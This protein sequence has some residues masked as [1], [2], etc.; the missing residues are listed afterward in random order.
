MNKYL[1]LICIMCAA[2]FASSCKRNVLKGE[3]DKT[4]TSLPVSSSF[5]AL[6]IALPLKSVINIAPGSQPSV[7]LSGYENVIRHIHAKMDKNTLRLETDLDEMW[8]LDSK[9]IS[10]IITV[11]SLVS[12]E[13]D[14]TSDA[15]IHGA[16]IAN[17]FHLSVSG[18][19]K[20]VIDNLTAPV[21]SADISGA[22]TLAINGGAARKS[23]YD[24][25]G[26][27]TI[28]AFSFQS[29]TTAAT[30]SGAGTCEVTARQQLNA[31]VNGAGTIKYKGHPGV[32]KD[33]S[34]IGTITDAN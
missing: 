2:L 8:T 19:S 32:V 27:G 1:V 12:L 3:G 17:D 7:Q 14:G 34:G 31:N 4:M 30:I 29:D 18:A 5:N 6:S 33:V 9:D 11:P 21:F 22:G 10:I 23:T 24:I 16:V 25:N 15:D 28:H 20:I 13:L 26:A